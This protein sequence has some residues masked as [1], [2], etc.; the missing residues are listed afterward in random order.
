[1]E[2]T[3]SLTIVGP[4]K[5]KPGSCVRLVPPP[6]QDMNIPVPRSYWPGWSS[7]QYRTRWWSH[8]GR[9]LTG[10][11]IWWV[12]DGGGGGRDPP[13]ALAD[14]DLSSGSA[15]HPEADHTTDSFSPAKKGAKA[16]MAG[17]TTS[18]YRTI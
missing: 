8:W 14:A 1:M 2:V 18:Y 7:T 16:D 11:W 13:A 6:Q 9:S 17:E 5:L 15:S 3:R 10:A 4:S 12:P